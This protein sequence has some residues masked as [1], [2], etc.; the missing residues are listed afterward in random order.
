MATIYDSR[1]EPRSYEQRRLVLEGLRDLRMNYY[2]GELEIIGFLPVP[3]ASFREKN[4]QGPRLFQL[5][6]GW[7]FN[8]LAKGG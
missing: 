6:H 5:I 7:D 2:D 8:Q 4:C 3:A 1:N